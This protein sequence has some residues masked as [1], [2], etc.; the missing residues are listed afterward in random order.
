MGAREISIYIY[1]GTYGNVGEVHEHKTTKE[2]KFSAK[3]GA[4]PEPIDLKRLLSMHTACQSTNSQEC[5]R[6]ITLLMTF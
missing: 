5:Q 6:L 2:C 1:I 4:L 3:R